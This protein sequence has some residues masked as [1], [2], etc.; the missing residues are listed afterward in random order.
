M[1]PLC[2]GDG[3]YKERSGALG[4]TVRGVTMADEICIPEEVNINGENTNRTAS[5]K[6][7]K[8][9]ET[10]DFSLVEDQRQYQ[11]Q[12]TLPMFLFSP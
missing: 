3:I 9:E 7:Q 8:E 5:S 4:C 6:N 12:M 1:A 10:T 11:G 2:L